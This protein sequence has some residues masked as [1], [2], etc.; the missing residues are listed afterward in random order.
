MKRPTTLLGML[1]H[2]VR[3]R[4]RMRHVALPALTL[5][6][7]ALAWSVQHRAAS[8]PPVAPSA[9]APVETFTRSPLRSAELLN[10]ADAHR[11]HVARHVVTRHYAA[12]YRGAAHLLYPVMAWNGHHYGIFYGVVTDYEVPLRFVRVSAQGERVG[13][14]VAVSAPDST[15]LY[16]HVTLAGNDF[17][18]AWTAL[19]EDFV[20][21]GF[22]RVS[23][24]GVRVGE[25]LRVTDPDEFNVWGVPAWSGSEYGVAWVHFGDQDAVQFQRINP[26]GEKAGPV[27]TSVEGFFAMGP[28][29][30]AWAERRYALAYTRLDDAR[31]QGVVTLAG[32]E[33]TG[34]RKTTLD[35]WRSDEW[36]EN[37]ALDPDGASL[38]L[39]W[40]DA[41]GRLGRSVPRVARARWESIELA[42]RVVG[43]RGLYGEIHLATS[44]K[45]YALTWRQSREGRHE[46]WF[47]QFNRQG[48]A[49]G[50]PV[51]LDT[52]SA[53]ADEFSEP[54]VVWNG[55]EYAVVWAGAEERT[56]G[57]AGVWFQRVSAEGQKVGV[58]VPVIT[59]TVNALEDCH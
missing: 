40:N 24:E 49:L 35:V 10:F 47:A 13:E 48:A 4:V 51:R 34:A 1:W 36:A 29:D 8:P 30:L 45:G 50:G 14:P 3:L 17:A 54:D 44:A 38:N 26:R 27:V 32:L 56:D 20:G 28:I 46:V 55:T 52:E 42:P 15:A 53:P 37:P 9:P 58:E 41:V 22:A 21:V 23:A 7:G 18:A 43:A 57:R 59:T 31:T 25:P 33:A 6:A 39:V 11:D 19:D 5:A 2:V 12:T 16:T